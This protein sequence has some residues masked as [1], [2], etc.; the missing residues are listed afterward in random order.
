M[1]SRIV[2]LAK[3]ILANTEKVDGHLKSNNLLQPSFDIDGPL[4]MELEVKEA[5]AAHIS[6]IEASMELQDLLLGTK[7]LLSPVV[8]FPRSCC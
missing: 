5:K 3:Q 4:K 6:A 2:E 7:T 1:D 8:C